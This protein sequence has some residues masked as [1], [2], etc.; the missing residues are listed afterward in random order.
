MYR[1]VQIPII[2]KRLNNRL[3]QLYGSRVVQLFSDLVRMEQ[4][5]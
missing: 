3:K 4:D 1:R 5:L 2:R